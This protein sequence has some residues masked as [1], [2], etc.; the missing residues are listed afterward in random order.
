MSARMKRMRK[1][2]SARSFYFPA[3][4]IPAGIL[5]DPARAGRRLPATSGRRSTSFALL[6]RLLRRRLS[7]SLILRFH[8]RARPRF[9]LFTRFPATYVLQPPSRCF[10]SPEN[11]ICFPFAARYACGLAFPDGSVHCEEDANHQTSLWDVLMLM[12]LC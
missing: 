3:R 1:T 2:G 5:R 8:A 7:V 4:A 9:F 10:L 11:S 12:L 6:S